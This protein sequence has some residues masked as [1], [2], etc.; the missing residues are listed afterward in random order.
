MS[1]KLILDTEAMHD[2][3]FTD[4]ALIGI[5]CA[6]PSYRFCGMMN[7]YFD[8]KLRRDG[9]FDICL[10]TAQNISHYFALYRY[11]APMNSNKFSVYRLKSNKQALLPELKQLDFLFMIQ[12]PD[13]DADAEKYIRA[14]RALNDVQLAQ[15][16][17]PDK[18]KNV[19]YLLV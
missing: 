17:Q 7:E 6:L 14:M 11:D 19:D 16:I 5:V 9:E 18:L 8:L 1:A 10:K 4:T 13:A 15:F 12:G 2:S 3:F